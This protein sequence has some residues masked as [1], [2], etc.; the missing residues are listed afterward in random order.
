MKTDISVIL[1]SYN[2]NIRYLKKCIDSILSQ[3]FKNFEFIIIINPDDINISFYRE[4]QS[5]DSRIKLLIN[6]K[7]EGVS[8]SRNKGINNSG[9]LFIAF[10]DSDDYYSKNRL[11]LQ[12]DY[13]KQE[14]DISVVGSNMILVNEDD[15]IIGH[16]LYPEYHQDIK[17]QFLY[18]MAIANPSILVRKDALDDVGF[19][20]ENFTK[21]EDI[22]LWL[23]F[24]ASKKKIHNLQEHLVFYR[25]KFDDNEKRGRVHYRN[26]YKALMEH[27]YN[28]WPFYK[29]I[30]PLIFF[31]IISLMPNRLLSILLNLKIVRSWKNIS[32][33]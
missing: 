7:P 33:F 20:N 5:Q 21:A 23:R 8:A 12:L 17:K 15:L 22:E 1:T 18:K 11:Q 26:Y 19:F 30:F 27:S 9:S 4:V 28:I 31:F 14:K 3:T 10:A 32:R 24:L 6:N 13:M 25:S 29:R 2:E 16:R